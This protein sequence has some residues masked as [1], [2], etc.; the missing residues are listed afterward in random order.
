MYRM[1]FRTRMLEITM[2]LQS[3][4]EFRVTV[5][6][7]LFKEFDRKRGLRQGDPAAGIL[8]IIVLSSGGNP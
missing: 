8:C 7:G 4:L 5:G 6:K 2:K 3:E 1:G